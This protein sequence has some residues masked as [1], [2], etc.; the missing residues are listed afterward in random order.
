VPR[1]VAAIVLYATLP[2]VSVHAQAT[3]RAGM[4]SDIH[5]AAPPRMVGEGVISTP[6]DEFKAT[7]SPDGR[8]LVYVVTDRTFGHMTILE[9]ARRGDAW[10]T[11]EVASFS[12]I[13]RDID[14]SYSPDGRTLL[15]ISN[16]P[17]PGDTPNTPRSDYNIWSVSR[18]PNGMWGEPV[19][20]DRQINTDSSEFAPSLTVAGTLY[21]ARGD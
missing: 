21:F 9:A 4:D 1:E 12:G 10:F 6:A 18:R 3:T 17:M 16:R 19:A 2:A 20:L 7:A 13:W 8:T 5:A 14:P 15:F 11:P